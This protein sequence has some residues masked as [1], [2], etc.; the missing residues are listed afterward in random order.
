[1]AT[2][3]NKIVRGAAAGGHGMNPADDEK[4]KKAEAER[5]DAWRQLGFATMLPF[6]LL[7]GAL[8]GW[9]LG[10]LLNKWLHFG[11]IGVGICILFGVAAGFREIF[12][13]LKNH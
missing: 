10:W 1:M 4:K 13:M 3:C 9:G 8:V 12:Y 6:M 2:G 5:Q 7:A 11:M